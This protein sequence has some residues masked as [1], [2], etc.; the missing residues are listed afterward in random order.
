VIVMYSGY[1]DL[2][3]NFAA[4]RHTSPIFRLTG[5]SPIL[6]LVIRE[7][8]MVIL[9][10]G[11]LELAYR[12][13]KTTFRPNLAQRTAG[14]A[15]AAVANV[16]ESLDKQLTNAMPN[17]AD[18]HRAIGAECGAPWA[19]YCGAVFAAAQYALDH[20][21]Q[22]LFASQ[23][24]INPRHAD[25]DRQVFAFLRRRFGDNP[26]VHLL[27]LSDAVALTDPALCYDGM[28]LTAAGNR[29]IAGK[30]AA[31]VSEMLQ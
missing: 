27:D 19:H 21:K 17:P 16:S 9:S 13:D 22:V 18:D 24:L 3:D 8:S 15:L 5:Y 4:F 30:L 1:N 31:P 10:G 7:K 26:R 14:S 28:H 11:N 25:Q 20:Q 6:P 12:R 23:P 2:A 29:I